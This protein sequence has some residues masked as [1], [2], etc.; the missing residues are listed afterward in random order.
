MKTKRFASI[1]I[2]LLLSFTLF[3][4]KKEVEIPKSIDKPDFTIDNSGELDFISLH[5]GVITALQSEVNP[6]FYI[7]EGE[8]DISGDSEKKNIVVT[9]TCINGTTIEDLDLFLSRV[10]C[11]IGI[12]CAEQNFKFK[13]PIVSKDGNY[14]S[15]GTVFDTYSLELNC[16]CENGLVLRNDKIKAGEEIPVDPRYWN[17]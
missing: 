7:K 8:F 13:A 16:K 6:F 4:C 11:F 2:V 12:E 17:E 5:N 9:C 3:S 14:K 15:F 10:L 1:F